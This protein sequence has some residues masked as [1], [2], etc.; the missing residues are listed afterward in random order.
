MP[1]PEETPRSRSDYGP[2]AKEGDMVIALTPEN[3]PVL[4]DYV[5]QCERRLDE[6]RRRADRLG[7]SEPAAGAS[8]M[9]A[10]GEQPW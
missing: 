8:G 9:P 1:P 10:A 5:Q 6:W 2:R 3:L 4:L 7:V